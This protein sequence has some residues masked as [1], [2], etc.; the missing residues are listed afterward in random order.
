MKI[1]I[2]GLG[3]IGGSMAKAISAHTDHLVYGFDKDRETLQMALNQGSIAAVLDEEALAQIDLLFLALYPQQAIQALK[4]AAPGLR[5]GTLVLDLCGVKQAVFEPLRLTAKENE[6][7]YIGAHPMA[8]RE[9]TGYAASLPEL[10]KDAYMILTPP[11]GTPQAAIQTV[12][13]L[14]R[15]IGFRGLT[16][17]NPAEHDRIIAYTSQLAHVVSC[18]YVQSPTAESFKGYSAGSFR[19]MTRVAKLNETMWTQLFLDNREALLE[20]I[21][22]LIQRL[23]GYHDLL[24]SGDGE[25]LKQ[26]LK[27]AR[28]K[29][30]AL[31]EMTRPC[32]N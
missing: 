11:E 2:I 1:G 18:A 15:K 25:G 31:E 20:E 23:Q 14:C 4:D 28:E 10:F 29:K 30:E 8:G 6:L 5:K 19:D 17:T 12:D 21:Q 7:I 22:G 26:R 24:N 16:L 27:N 3:L 32:N 13:M 9:L